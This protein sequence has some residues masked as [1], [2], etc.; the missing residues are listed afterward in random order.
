MS[1]LFQIPDKHDKR[2]QELD[3]SKSEAEIYTA[4]NK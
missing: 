4:V 2:N 3:S 1:K